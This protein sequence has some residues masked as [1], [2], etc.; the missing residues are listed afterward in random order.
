MNKLRTLISTGFCSVL[1]LICCASTQAQTRPRTEPLSSQADYIIAIVNSEPITFREVLNQTLRAE[2]QLTQQ[3]AAL[4]PREQMIRQV[5]E[6]LIDDRILVQ[7]ARESGI[8]IDDTALNEAVANIA[9]QNQFSVE[10]LYRQLA[11]DGVDKARFLS[12]IRDEML[13][14]RFRERDFDARIRISDNEVEDFIRE[15]AAQGPQEARIELNLAQ[16][17]IERPEQASEQQTQVLRER[18]ESIRQRLLSGADFGALSREFSTAP[19]KN[20][21]GIM[22]LRN[23]NRYPESFVQAT[24][25]LPEGGISSV[26]QSDAGFHIVKLIE[27]K[28]ARLPEMAI[29]QTLS[30]HI[31]LDIK[32][33][34]SE[35]SA[36]QQLLQIRQQIVAG[37]ISFEDMA[38]QHST[39]GSATQGGDLGWANPGWFVPEFEQVLNNLPPGAISDPFTS[40]FGV[41]IVQVLSRRKHVLEQSEQREIVRQSLKD[42]R[43]QERLPQWLRDLRGNAYI[44]Y[45]QAPEF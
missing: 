10:Q 28:Q 17:L 36:K 37:R 22:G 30:R 2:Q 45:R 26:I 6:K 14:T 38:K 21:G 13:A 16:I 31:L 32:P 7:Q 4:A 42:K 8:K 24:S 5:L 9:R 35:E 3:G 18:A 25:S 20:E 12:D 27:K 33:N 44:E 19:T 29:T 43:Y 1:L 41:H 23:A 15:Q 39:D 11:K 34:R 40:R